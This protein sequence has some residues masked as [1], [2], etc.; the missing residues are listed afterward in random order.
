MNK[1]SKKNALE[2]VSGLT[3]GGLIEFFY[4][5]T[6][7]LNVEKQFPDGFEIERYCIV[8]SN[9]GKF[10]NVEDERHGSEFMAKPK[11]EIADLGNAKHAT[12]QGKCPRCKALI[13]CIAKESVCPICGA[14]VECT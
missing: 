4:E 1:P 8:R 3:E 10:K 13:A 5:A 14:I 6:D 9:Y 7:H 2:Y 12:E 11:S